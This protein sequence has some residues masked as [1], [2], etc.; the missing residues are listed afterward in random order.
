MSL[1]ELKQHLQQVKIA[2]LAGLCAIFKSTPA[3][4]QP[5]LDFWIRKG[6]LRRFEQTNNCNA[7]CATCLQCG[8]SK[9]EFYEW[10]MD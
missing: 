10:V 8:I 2:T 1:I 6:C 3:A 9:N 5:M 4:M 7:P